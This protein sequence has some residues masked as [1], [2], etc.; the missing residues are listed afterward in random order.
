VDDLKD[1]MDEIAAQRAEFV[2][3][4]ALRGIY[5]VFI[6]FEPKWDQD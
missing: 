6:E 4:K 1:K 3:V 2:V 5:T